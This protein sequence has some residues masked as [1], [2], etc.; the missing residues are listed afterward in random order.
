MVTQ[1]DH[2]DLLALDEVLK[3]LGEKHPDKA[4]V[5]EMRYFGGLTNDEAAEVLGVTTRT[6]ER[7]WQ[8]ARTWLYREL[9]GSETDT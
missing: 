7:H 6:V 3:K 8:F 4:S 9:A 2:G 5:V 1:T